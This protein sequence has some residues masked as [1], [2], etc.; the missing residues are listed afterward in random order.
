MIGPVRPLDSARGRPRG[1]LDVA[2]LK[3]LVAADAVRTVIVGFPDA[4]GRLMGKRMAAGFFLDDVLQRGVGVSTYLL[5]CDLSM[6]AVDGYHVANWHQGFGDMRLV[7]DV[8]TLRLASWLDRTAVVICDAWDAPGAGM[9]EVAPRTVLRRQIDRA[10][11]LG[12][13]PFVASELELYICNETY[14]EAARKHHLDLTPAGSEMPAYD[15]LQTASHEPL[16]SQLRDHLERSGVPVEASIGEFGPGQEEINLRYADVLEMA[17]RHTLF[18]HAAKEIAMQQGRSVTFMAAW[19]TRHMGSGLH[20]HLSMSDPTGTRPMFPGT[21]RLGPI[22]CS[23]LFKRFLAG[24]MA[25]LRDIFPFYAPYPNSYKRFYP[26]NTPMHNVW[27]VDH[28]SVAFR[29]L[30]RDESVRIECRV[31]GADANPYL[32]YAAT[33]AAGLDGIERETDPPPPFEGDPHVGTDLPAL[34]RTLS[35]ALAALAGSQWARDAFG[36]RVVAHYVHF[37]RNEQRLHDEAVT[38]WDRTRYFERA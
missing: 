7:P 4:Y 6:S 5:A 32:A 17:D 16:V 24:W 30:G 8:S 36:E 13:R 26:Y 38:D 28:R 10:A 19:D 21:S 33:L 14:E 20:I 18:K 15:I 9:I 2:E 37:F 1:V 29:V 25:R 22:C 3:A 35:E 23:P 34:P 31:P 27:S 11:A 12:L